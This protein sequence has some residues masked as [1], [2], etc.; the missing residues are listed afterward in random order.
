MRLDHLSF[1]KEGWGY[2]HPT[3]DVLKIFNDLPQY[4]ND[5][6]SIVEIG[7]HAGHS[8]TYLL[9]TFKEADIYCI[10][11]SRETKNASDI[12]KRVYGDRFEFKQKDS[13]TTTPTEKVDVDLSFVDGNHV[14]HYVANDII[15]SMCWGS[16]Y[17]LVDN[18]ERND[19]KY[20]VDAILGVPKVSFSYEAEWNNVK[21]I[22]KMNLY[23]LQRN[24]F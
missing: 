13:L 22:N 10:G 8:T 9:E 19:V 4:V 7:F 24:N 16:R 12:M 18:C 2:L 20:V 21:T 5:I 14:I 11:L 6:R 3:E 23:A 17:I 15:K 1:P